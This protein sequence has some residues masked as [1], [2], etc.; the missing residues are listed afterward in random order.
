MENFIK[1]SWSKPNSGRYAEVLNPCTG[2]VVDTFACSDL[3]DVAQVM[4]VA[5]E[6]YRDW[7]KTPVAVRARLQH[8]AA[9]LMREQADELAQILAQEL[10]R[11]MV[12]CQTEISRSADLLD[13][14]AEEGLRLKGEIPLH[15]LDG[16]KAL[17]VRE[18][19]GVVVA[20]T[21]F[22]YPI[23]LLTMK[24][25][26]ALIA[27]CAV[28]SKPS[29]DTPLSTLRLAELFMQA[30]YPAGVFNVITGYGH[31]IGNALID[32]PATAKIAFTG[33]TGTGKRIGALAAMHNK[34]VTLELGGQSPAIVCADANLAVAVPAIVRHAFANSGQFCYRVNRLYVH[35]SIYDGFLEQMVALTANL[36]VGHPQSGADMGPM[37]NAKIY[38]NSEVQVA[39]ALSK[40]A[41]LKTGG[42]R[43][44]GPDYDNGWF[45]PPTVLANTDH[46]MKIMTEET[47]GPVVGVMP[48]STVEEAVQRAND[49]EYGLAGYVFSENLSTGLRVAESL[50]AGS[51]WINNIHRSYH[52]VPFGG[53][54]QSGIGREKGRYGVEAY[55]ELK[56]IYLNY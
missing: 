51:V 48:F 14:Y 4:Q 22:N 25:G 19:V 17:I 15:N 49:S 10:G 20:I 28:V 27:G 30:G 12:G 41:V 45:F 43:L 7:R 46:S 29:E 6:A 9:R 24:L 11:P 53:Y 34:R 16:E 56:T 1:G 18:P 13:F 23:T 32:H 55:T 35:E 37:V 3:T 44:T 21:P 5:Q 38:Q 31:E 36:R 50:E 54:K 8:A 47:F 2:A 33:G 39:D 26:A 42:Q 52:D 40:G